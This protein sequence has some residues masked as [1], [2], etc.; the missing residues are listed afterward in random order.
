MA[1]QASENVLAD[2]HRGDQIPARDASLPFRY[3]E[4][5]RNDRTRRVLTPGRLVIVVKAMRQGPVAQ[6]G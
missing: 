3:S 5:S 2:R 6:S 4:Y 1:A